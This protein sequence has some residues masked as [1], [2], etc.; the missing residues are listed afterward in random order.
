M[1]KDNIL[2]AI[3]YIFQRCLSEAK[4]HEAEQLTANHLNLFSQD[5]NL[6]DN[7]AVILN[8]GFSILEEN[9][10]KIV[11]QDGHV[12]K[13]EKG[14]EKDSWLVPVKE[15]QPNF[16]ERLVENFKTDNPILVQKAIRQKQEGSA[17]DLS[18]REILEAN[19]KAVASLNI[20]VSSPHFGGLI[21]GRHWTC[22]HFNFGNNT[23]SYLDS[24]KPNLQEE[25]VKERL[26][27]ALEW[28]KAN[29]SAGDKWTID[30]KD[31]ENVPPSVLKDQ[32]QWDSFNC[33]VF[34]IRFTVLAGKG[35]T[36]EQ[37]N[38]IPFSDMYRQ[39]EAQRLEVM[40]CVNA[41]LKALRQEFSL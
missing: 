36:Y 11:D 29:D 27:Q 35:Y 41:K 5:F 14:V 10:G 28:L 26:N 31:S 15:G 32:K 7:R 17:K 1:I 25:K 9:A 16:F 12:E 8:A 24:Q 30:V 37:I 2:G 34:A 40:N 3:T 20:N 23:I 4:L 33:G 13:D 38:K 21:E 18:L 39:I 6:T 22:I 19:N